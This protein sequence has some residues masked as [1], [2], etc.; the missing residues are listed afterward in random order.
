MIILACT[1]VKQSILDDEE[2]KN[3]KKDITEIIVERVKA[4]VSSNPNM[5]LKE[6]LNFKLFNLDLII[7]T[8][9]NVSNTD[10]MLADR[11]SR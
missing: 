10:V 4:E 11:L 6:N 9:T 1:G 8:D 3:S 5:D 2:L 7:C